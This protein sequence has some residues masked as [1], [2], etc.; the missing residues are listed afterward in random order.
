M[1]TASGRSRAGL[2]TTNWS[3]LTFPLTT[4]SPRPQDDEMT[5]TRGNPVSGSRVNITP[6]DARSERTIFC[7]PTERA[8]SMWSKPRSSR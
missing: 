6:A 1:G 2:N 4:D 8:I 5:V 3:G 7:T